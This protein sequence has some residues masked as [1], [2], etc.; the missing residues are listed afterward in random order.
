M[1]KAFPFV[2]SLVDLSIKHALLSWFKAHPNH[3]AMSSL[4]STSDAD[5]NSGAESEADALT[6]HAAQEDDDEALG[7][8]HRPSTETV[9]SEFCRP[10]EENGRTYHSYGSGGK[11]ILISCHNECLTSTRVSPTER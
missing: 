6:L 7:G 8:M 11:L 9:A 10:I 2:G 1:V 3:T 4:P 5:D